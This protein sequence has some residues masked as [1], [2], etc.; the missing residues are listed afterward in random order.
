MDGRSAST[1]GRCRCRLGESPNLR[2]KRRFR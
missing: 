2:S 1:C